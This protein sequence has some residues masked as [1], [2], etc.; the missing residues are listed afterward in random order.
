MNDAVPLTAKPG[1]D[2]RCVCVSI[3]VPKPLVLHSHHVWPLGE[4]GPDVSANLLWLCPTSHN[5]AH[6]LWRLYDKHGGAVPVIELREFS[7]YVRSIVARGWSEK[8]AAD[9]EESP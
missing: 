7:R 8:A 2:K 4:G 3:H 5:N 1:G 9:T 6:A